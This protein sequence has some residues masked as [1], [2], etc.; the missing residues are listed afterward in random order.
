MYGK[1]EAQLLLT[2]QGMSLVHSTHHNAPL[3]HL[4]FF[5]FSYTCVW[6]F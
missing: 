1:Q 2:Q 5:E 6:D 4:A 3:G